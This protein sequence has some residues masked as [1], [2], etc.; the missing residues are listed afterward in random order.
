MTAQNR[1]VAE[2]AAEENAGRSAAQAAMPYHG[3]LLRL[4]S[5]AVLYE[6][7]AQAMAAASNNLRGEGAKLAPSA[8]QYQAVGQTVEARQILV[9]AHSLVDQ[10][11]RLTEQATQLQATA[12]EL[13]ND[14]PMYQQAEQAAAENAAAAA[15]PPAL[16]PELP[17]PY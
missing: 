17:L 16:P 10:S 13:Y 3:N 6:R 7:R 2:K 15:N 14:I 11:E 12:Q 4:Q 5:V 9:Q 1:A 8:N